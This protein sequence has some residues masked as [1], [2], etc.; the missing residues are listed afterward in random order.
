MLIGAVSVFLIP[1]VAPSIVLYDICRII[2][3]AQMTVILSNPFVNDYVQV[4]SRGIATSFQF[5]GLIF[6]GLVSI[7]VIFTIT[8][9]FMK[10]RIVAFGFLSVL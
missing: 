1:I 5:F 7:M 4:Q 10:N 3:V 2:Y 8:E 6:G 9:N